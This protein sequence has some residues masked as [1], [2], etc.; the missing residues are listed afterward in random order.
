MVLVALSGVQ[1][2]TDARAVT[3][4]LQFAFYVAVLPVLLQAPSVRL[5]AVGA[6]LGSGALATLCVVWSCALWTGDLGG[7]GTAGN[8]LIH[9]VTLAAVIPFAVLFLQRVRSAWRRSALGVT[10]A[11]ATGVTVTSLPAGCLCLLSTA[12]AARRWSQPRTLAVALV[13]AWTVALAVTGLWGAPEAARRSVALRDD[14]GSLRRWLQEDIAAVRATVAAPLLGHGLGRYQAIVSSG[15][16]RRDLPRPGETRVE[17]GMAPGLLVSAVEGGLPAT[18]ALLAL[19]IAAALPRRHEL[20]AANE[21]FAT[22]ARHG[23]LCLGAGFLLTVVTARSGGLLC[24]VLLGLARQTGSWPAERRRPRALT[25]AVVVLLALVGLLVCRHLLGQTPGTPESG[26]GSAPA[27]PGAIA[28]VLTADQATDIA[29]G[30]ERPAEPGTAAQRL[31]DVPDL[32]FAS[33]LPERLASWSFSTPQTARVVLWFRVWWQDGCGNSLAAGIDGHRPL[34]VGNDGTYRAWHWVRGPAIDLPAGPHVLAL[35]PR[36]DGIRL[37]QILIA[38]E[39]APPPVGPL[40]PDGSALAPPAARLAASTAPSVSPMLRETSFRVGVGGCYQGGFTAALLAMG[41]PWGKVNDGDLTHADRLARFAII[42]LSETKEVASEPMYRALRSFVEAGGVLLHENCTGEVPREYRRNLVFFPTPVGW[43]PAQAYG[44]TLETD[45]SELFAGIPAGTRIALHEEVPH[46]V[47]NGSPGPE[48]TGH[49][50]VWVYGRDDGAAVWTRQLGKGRIV[51]SRIPFSFHTMWRGPALQAPL[52]SLLKAL[53][54]PR[55]A[56]VAPMPAPEPTAAA[57]TVSDDFMRV[58]PDPGPA[59]ER[60]GTATCTGETAP[61]P[62][63]E[64][65]LLMEAGAR[66]TANQ[67]LAT[68]GAVSAAVLPSQG[69]GGI[70][71]AVEGGELRWIVENGTSVRLDQRRGDESTTLGRVP[72]PDGGGWHRLSLVRRD[73]AWEAFVDGTRGLRVTGP[74]GQTTQTRFGLWCESGRLF[75][76]D[77]NGR[78]SAGL[79]DG[80]D[81]ALGEEGSSL[82][83]GGLGQHGIERATVYSLRWH[84]R[85]SAI[86][87]NAVELGLP[88]YVPGELMRDGRVVAAVPATH[89]MATVAFRDPAISVH[90]LGFACAG[91]RDYVFSGRLTDWF[92]SGADWV[93]LSRWSCDPNWYWLGAETHGQAALWYRP[94]LTPPYAISAVV[95][96]GARNRFAEEYSRGRDMNLALG[97]T[98]PDVL[99]GLVVRV[100]NAADRGI[101]VWQGGALRQRFDGIGLPSG[102]SLHHNW[103]EVSAVVEPARLRVGFEGLP[104]GDVPLPAPATPGRVAVW[105]ENNSI[106]VARVTL[107]LSPP[108]GAA[109]A[110]SDRR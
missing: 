34:L 103:F 80:T 2:A 97:A 21:S 7:A 107:S 30:V 94:V 9:G 29:V 74:P 101:E 49:G 68:A 26:H 84:L 14:H 100:M 19:F 105:T 104:L 56:P 33:A 12:S 90:T 27:R 110:A 72:L 71:V 50:T 37:D 77:V 89:E 32:A 63:T 17:P 43:R 99:S 62:H 15:T 109:S 16:Y 92:G 86:Y 24:G 78:P 55:C 70:W 3:E 23:V 96:V 28:V 31:L 13:A 40:G 10:G 65:S 81:R 4:V 39:T 85:T 57:D 91:W 45:N 58:G 22:A 42:C 82:S 38:C 93:P 20:P 35:V 64:F 5:H 69:S 73:G 95:S 52:Q 44:A 48:W 53:V 51:Y 106:R 61:V 83:W 11:L 60:V 76:D 8:R 88:N 59:W 98:G 87:A 46:M 79:L 1:A 108:H 54:Q 36:E 102:H 67:V 47:R 41:L 6:G 75:V 66:I 18:A 25:Q